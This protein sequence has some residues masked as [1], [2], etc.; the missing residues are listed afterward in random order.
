M[1]D[2]DFETELRSITD[3]ILAQVHLATVFEN[4]PDDVNTIGFAN[5]LDLFEFVIYALDGVGLDEPVYSIKAKDYELS[6]RPEYKPLG[7]AKVMKLNQAT[8][9]TT[10]QA[11]EVAKGVSS[12]MY[13]QRNKPI[14]FDA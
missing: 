13:E 11:F 6:V 1:I 12:A 10:L 9:E 2:K 3:N 14:K 7:V 4:I 5:W 8:I